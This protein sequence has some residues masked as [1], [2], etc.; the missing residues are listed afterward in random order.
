MPSGRKTRPESK[1][2]RQTAIAST[3]LGIAEDT[4]QHQWVIHLKSFLAYLAAVQGDEE[5]FRR[6]ATDALS[7]TVP[8]QGALWVDW[9][10]GMLDLGSGRVDAALTRLEALT[11]GPGW[12]HVSAMRCVP[13]LVEAAVRS[14]EPGRA[15]HAFAR[16]ERWARQPFTRALAERCRAL[17]GSDADAEERYLAALE[18]GGPPFEHARTSL[19][20]GEWLRRSRRRGP[21]PGICN[22]RWRPSSAWARGPGPTAPELSWKRP[23]RR[24]RA[25]RPA[26][27]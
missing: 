6:L 20:Y 17:L 12:Y 26:G 8:M 1:A 5:R 24:P 9:G 22:S 27:S 2:E 3:A 16:Y 23:A 7:G 10:Q 14:G 21:P 15:H 25:P 4:G 19:Q 13:D 18:A 11:Q